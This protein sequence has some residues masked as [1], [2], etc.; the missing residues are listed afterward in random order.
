MEKGKSMSECVFMSKCVFYDQGWNEA[1]Y[2]SKHR[3]YLDNGCGDCKPVTVDDMATGDI[4]KVVR[5]KDCKFWKA[6]PNADELDNWD[7]GWC[8]WKNDDR[9]CHICGNENDYC[10]YGERKDE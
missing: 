7:N 3:K 6:K 1:P 4:V 9:D 5:C 10:S 8:G 2:C